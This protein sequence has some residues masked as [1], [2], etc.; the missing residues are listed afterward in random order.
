MNS[1]FRDNST[2]IGFLEL[3]DEVEEIINIPHFTP[4][5]PQDDEIG[6]RIFD[7]FY[8]LSH[9]KKNSDGF[10]ILLVGYSRSPFRDFESYLRS[11]VALAEEN[12]QLILK[13]I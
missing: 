8:K 11:V 7:E 13:T 12:I 4:E 10:M 1:K 3:K 9:E 6:P 5:H 2:K